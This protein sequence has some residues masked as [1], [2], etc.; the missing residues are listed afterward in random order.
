MASMADR[1]A[2]AEVARARAQIKASLVMSLES[3]AGRADQIAR[4]FLALGRVPDVPALMARIDQV[5]ARDVRDLAGRLF[6]G[7]KPAVS[8][9]GA[10]SGL[11][12]YERIAARFS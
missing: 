5:T 8:A 11:P 1:V 3:A 7:Q 12:A 6:Q 2:E 9:V 10:L 4:Q